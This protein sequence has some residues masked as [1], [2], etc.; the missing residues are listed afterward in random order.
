MWQISVTTVI[1]HDSLY[2]I[3]VWQP[4]QDLCVTAYTKYVCDSLYKI[5]VWQPIQNMCV[6]AYTRSVCDSLY[7]ICVKAETIDND[8]LMVQQRFWT[9]NLLV[10][11][12]LTKHVSVRIYKNIKTCEVG[13]FLYNTIVDVHFFVSGYL[14]KF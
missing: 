13:Y 3:C 5:C 9:V 4:I 11:W 12:I 14:Y 6:T 7:K 8:D 2:K 1:L 10:Q